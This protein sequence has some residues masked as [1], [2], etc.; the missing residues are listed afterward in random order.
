MSPSAQIL[1]QRVSI[2]R[3]VQGQDRAGGLAPTYPDSPTASNV[4]CSTQAQGFVETWDQG[5]LSVVREWKLYFAQA[6]T[7]KP[8]DKVVFS[9]PAGTHT[10]Y[11]EADRD[12]ASRGMMYSIK[13]I[14]RT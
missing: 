11:V 2:Y 10:V 4:P 6:V 8:R 5:Q 9:D 12:E 1:K 14:E 13:A 7:V 3:A